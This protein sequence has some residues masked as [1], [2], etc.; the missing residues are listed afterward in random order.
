MGKV[1]W[2]TKDGMNNTQ[3]RVV[4]WLKE[5]E[6]EL[7]KLYEG[8]VHLI[9]ERAFPGRGRFICHAVREIRNRLPDAVAGKGEA[10]HLE[11]AEEVTLIA[12]AWAK[13]GLEGAYE[14]Q[15]GKTGGEPEEQVLREVLVSVDRLVRRHKEVGGRKEK[16]AKRLLIALEPENKMLQGSLGPVVKRWLEETEWF[17][18]RSHIGRTIDESELIEHFE[19]FEN[20]LASLVGF[21]YERFDRIN[22]I[23]RDANISGSKPSD[24]EVREAISFLVRARFRMHFFSELENPHWIKPLKD[25][26]FF[27]IPQDAK[28]GEAYERWPEGWYLKKVSSKVPGEVLGIISGVT[29]K[30]GRAHV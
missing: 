9:S 1:F 24:G 14:K 26:G 19:I 17:V 10:K 8:A 25:A 6:P 21:F 29:C 13:A 18:E 15:S 16:N 5:L 30:I 3:K 4:D 2:L 22:Q 20:V 28:E 7:G 11:Y 27:K 23:V 12:K